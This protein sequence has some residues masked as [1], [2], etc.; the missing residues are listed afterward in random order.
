MQYRK[1]FGLSPEQFRTEVD[2]QTYLSDLQM[3]SIE[4]EANEERVAEVKAEHEE[5]SQKS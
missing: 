4:S 5:I 1:Y 3:M 2:L